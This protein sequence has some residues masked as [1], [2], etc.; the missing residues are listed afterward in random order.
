M[1]PETTKPLDGPD[2]AP[3]GDTATAMLAAGGLLAAFGVASC[4][5]LPVALSLFGVSAASLAGIGALAGP[6]QRELFLGAAACIGAAGFLAWRRAG[7]AACVP[8]AACRRPV[9]DWA[10]R[11]A[12]LLAASLLALA[13]WIEPPL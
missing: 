9:V 5:A 13:L 6:Y 4:C 10:S 8:G 11:A 1:T 3:R 12:A 7:A 2:F